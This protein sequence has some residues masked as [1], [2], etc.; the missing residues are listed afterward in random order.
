V[1]DLARAYNIDLLGEEAGRFETTQ[2]R[3]L[4]EKFAEIE[5]LTISWA[6]IDISSDQRDYLA[7]HEYDIPSRVDCDFQMAKE[8]IFLVKTLRAMEQ[9]ALVVCGWAHTFS[10]AAK[11]NLVGCEVVT[12]V[13]DNVRDI[14]RIK[15]VAF[16]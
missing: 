7:E 5:G 8:W 11:F 3:K 4:I 15:A 9:S 2:T 16:D 6:N 13:Y 10:L 14:N 1:T 12:C